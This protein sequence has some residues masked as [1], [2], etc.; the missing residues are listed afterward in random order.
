MTKETVLCSRTA[1]I[2]L[3]LNLRWT[4][5]M[6]TRLQLTGKST[7]WM[8]QHSKLELQETVQLWIYSQR[9]FFILH[10]IHT[11]TLCFHSLCCS[12]MSVYLI[13]VSA[14]SLQQDTLNAESRACAGSVRERPAFS[15]SLDLGRD[16][17]RGW[18]ADNT[19][20]QVLWWTSQSLLGS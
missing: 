12:F 5:Q 8:L 3:N 20:L 19:C 7:S 1:V 11:T 14:F 15:T 2:G 9:K 18:R 13:P 4:V 10:P 17:W 6:Q 16:T